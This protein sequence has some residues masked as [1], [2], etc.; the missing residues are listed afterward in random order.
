M[1]HPDTEVRYISPEIG[2]GVVA[3]RPIPRGT[4]TW[5][6]DALDRTFPTEEL[7]RF[8]AL[9]QEVLDKY[10]YRNR[11]GHYVFCWDHARF[12]NHSANSNC[13]LTPYRLE[14]AIRDIAPGEELTN[15][16]GCFNI[17]EPFQP[18]AEEGGR[19]VVEP[20]DLARCHVGWDDKIRTAV[21]DLP[22]VGQP[23][24]SLICQEDWEILCAAAAGKGNLDSVTTMLF[25]EDGS[26]RR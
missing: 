9:L 17:I 11:L 23:L 6:Q 1:I 4:V 16:Y 26:A 21:L 2:Y 3:L 5:V 20:D 19:D 12:M 8:P 10:C 25:R 7:S 15:D 22:G 14:I 24:R 18:C 13:L